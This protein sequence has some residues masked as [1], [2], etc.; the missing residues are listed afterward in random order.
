M[1]NKSQC[2]TLQ[3]DGKHRY[4]VDGCSVTEFKTITQWEIICLLSTAVTTT[5]IIFT[6]LPQFGFFFYMGTWEMRFWLYDSFAQHNKYC[7]YFLLYIPF[8][9]PLY[10]PTLSLFLHA[11]SAYSWPTCPTMAMI[12]WVFTHLSTWPP[13]FAHGQTWNCTPSHPCSSHTSTSSFFP[14][15]GTHSGRCVRMGICPQVW[16]CVTC[17]YICPVHFCVIL[18]V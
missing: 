4:S 11:R 5:V 8:P 10:P 3:R 13:S 15:K 17:L 18:I 1:Y 6:A 2:V 12:D 16:A 9:F 7:I 14:N